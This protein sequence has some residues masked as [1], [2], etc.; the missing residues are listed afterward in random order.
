MS[1]PIRELLK[2]LTAGDTSQAEILLHDVV[3]QKVSEKFTNEINA[4]RQQNPED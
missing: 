4:I 1:E 2:S 3:S